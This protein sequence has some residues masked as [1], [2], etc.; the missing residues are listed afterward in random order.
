MP[1][2]GQAQPFQPVSLK[3]RDTDPEAFA[4]EL[5]DSFKRY[6]FGVIKD[7]G[8]DR[9]VIERALDRAQEFFALPEDVKRAYLVEGGGG[10]RG[11]VPF[12]Q[13]KA[14]GFDAI[15]L[16]EFWH[17]GRD[18]PEG[19]RHAD[20]MPPNLDVAEIDDWHEATY[21]MFEEL[22]ALG[23]KV[24]SSIADYLGIATDWFADAVQDG[25]SILRLLHYPPQ[26]EPPPEG[27]VR[28]AEHGDI[29]VI[30]LL[31]GAEEGGL[32]V[33]DRDGT[34]LS[35]SP[36]PDCIVINMGDM[37]ERLTNDYLPSTLHRVVNPK[38]ERSRFPRYST[39][40]F[41]HFRPD[42]EIRTLESCITED[43]PNRY[44]E[45]ITANEFLVQRLKDINLM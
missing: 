5:G 7:H 29:N 13:E 24:L 17:V 30:T 1:D 3:L 28:A 34:W 42:F 26:L 9:A 32:E 22:D 21:A 36:P 40:F 43:N 33:K 11:Y 19:H 41:L 10:Q 37:L 44:P 18:L 25:N 35:I 4:K 31:L 20:I 12:G 39:P 45:P 8:L 27:S 14:K 2:N 23:A 16:K 15:D 6:G 38:P